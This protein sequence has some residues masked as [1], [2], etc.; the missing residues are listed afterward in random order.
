MSELNS[1]HKNTRKDKSQK[2]EDDNQ[3]GYAA[4]LH[5]VE[6]ISYD[7]N[8]GLPEET[9]VFL[10]V[11]HKLI[12]NWT[13]E[14]YIPSSDIID[15]T[16]ISHKNLGKYQKNLVN[17]QMLLVTK[18]KNEK[19]KTIYLYRLHPSRYGANYIYNEKSRRFGIIQG[20][21]QENNL[22]K[23]DKN[24]LAEDKLSSSRRA[25][26][27]PEPLLEPQPAS[28]KNPIKEPIKN[29]T[30]EVVELKGSS[31]EGIPWEKAKEQL[32][33][34]YPNDHLK[35]L[36]AYN[37]IT[38]SGEFKGCNVNHPAGFILK[39]WPHWRDEFSFVDDY[40]RSKQPK[41]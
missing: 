15:A 8:S 30:G 10:F 20:G 19:G 29:N 23:E 40:Q 12:R 34:I 32:L 6:E 4:M 11:K 41:Q 22:P 13:I 7:P 17:S 18:S 16:G 37:Q 5:R 27:A 38:L 2:K 36:T 14:L 25:K 28:G 39:G 26:Q 3:G 9:R 35:L 33:K 21:L 1:Q 31:G 24:L